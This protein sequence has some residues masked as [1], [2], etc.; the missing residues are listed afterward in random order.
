MV[1]VCACAHVRALL[2][3]LPDCLTDGEDVMTALQQQEMKILQEV[4]K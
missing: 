2:G 4:L 1:C 3:A